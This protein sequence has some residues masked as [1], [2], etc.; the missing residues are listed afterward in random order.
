MLH[1]VVL[2]TTVEE[3]RQTLL[4]CDNKPCI[5]DPKQWELLN[6]MVNAYDNCR[7]SPTCLTAESIANA[8]G[9]HLDWR[10]QELLTLSSKFLEKVQTKKTYQPPIIPRDYQVQR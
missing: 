4:A 7:N 1:D 10:V 2:G 6:R 5:M 3:A 8:A 9:T